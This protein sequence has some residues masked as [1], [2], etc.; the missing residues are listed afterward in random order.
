MIKLYL[1]FGGRKQALQLYKIIYQIIIT[2]YFYLEFSTTLQFWKNVILII[3]T[4][5]RVGMVYPYI[6]LI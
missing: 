3:L 2:N 6:E 1:H 5:F 4:V